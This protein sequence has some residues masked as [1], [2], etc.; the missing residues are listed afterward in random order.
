MPLRCVCTCVDYC[1]RLCVSLCV[2]KV[3]IFAFS[4]FLR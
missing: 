3:L 4:T 2:S 1:E